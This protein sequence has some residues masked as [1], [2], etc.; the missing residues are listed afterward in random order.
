MARA[1]PCPAAGD[2]HVSRRSRPAGTASPTPAPKLGPTKTTHQGRCAVDDPRVSPPIAG[3]PAHLCRV[4]RR[5]AIPAGMPVQKIGKQQ[6]RADRA[7]YTDHHHKFMLS[8]GPLT[9][10]WAR[11]TQCILG[12]T[13]PSAQ[14]VRLICAQLRR[15]SL[16]RQTT[17]VD[18]RWRSAPAANAESQSGFGG[19]F[20]DGS[21][22]VVLFTDDIEEHRQESSPCCPDVPGRA[23]GNADGPTPRCSRSRSESADA[24]SGATIHRS[25]R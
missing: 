8:A 25:P 12:E 15:W 20:V 4:A 11:S 14:T 22:L 6:Q 9:D 16:T 23:F 5:V 13:H 19:T 3:D 2:R 17:S 10:Q 21:T 7:H 18:G 1:R 24:C